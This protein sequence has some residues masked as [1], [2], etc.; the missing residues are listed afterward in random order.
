MFA[1]YKFN[2]ALDNH[3]KGIKEIKKPEGQITFQTY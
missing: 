3:V 1:A 2:E